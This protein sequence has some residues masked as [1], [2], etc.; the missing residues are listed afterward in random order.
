MLLLSRQSLARRLGALALAFVLLLQTACVTAPP[1]ASAARPDIGRVAIVSGARLP[2]MAFDGFAHGKGEGALRAAGGTFADCLSGMG[3]GCSGDFCGIVLIIALGFCSAAGVVGGVMGAAK[4]PAATRVR[5]AE[6]VVTATV[7]GADV[8]T[9]L[10]G[11]ITANALAAGERLVELSPGEAIA[12]THDYAG[13]A[14][15][16][17]QTVLE[18][19]L[20]EV[21]TIGPGTS[22]PVAFYMN[23]RARL[24]RTA[25]GEELLR[26]DY[27]YAGPRHTISE[28]ADGE[29]RLL[30]EALQ[31]GYEALGRHV[32]ENVL[33]LYPL[34]GRELHPVGATLEGFGLIPAEALQARTVR[35]GFMNLPR[36][37]WPRPG[38]LQPLLQWE[39]FPRA[40]DV[41]A[42]PEDMA[43]VERVRYDVMV[44]REQD[45]AQGGAVYRRSG[46]PDNSHEVETPLLPGSDYL[47]TV[48][49][50]FELDGRERVTEWATLYRAPRDELAAP[51]VLAYR[52]RTP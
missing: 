31:A 15:L 39:P 2:N 3:G 5:A 41:A 4:T 44:V 19:N 8:Q 27:S 1:E 32:Y 9:A 7:A 36:T 6:S 29:G 34:P 16:G 22:E 18:A 12:D 10:Q 13:L 50:R 40:C 35:D 46:L 43:R 25:D 38:T 28:W 26:R 30:R 21:G 14:A 20:V 51:P 24:V 17:A 33:A 47:W 52:F 42:A 45:A 49:A 48:R 11:N 23:A 37:E